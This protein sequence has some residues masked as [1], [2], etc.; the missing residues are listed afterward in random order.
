MKVLSGTLNT[1]CQVPKQD[2]QYLTGQLRALGLIE[3]IDASKPHDLRRW[4]L[5][6]LGKAVY[7]REALH[8]T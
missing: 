1:A 8:T 2:V 7:T 4:Q 5:T 6:G 3:L